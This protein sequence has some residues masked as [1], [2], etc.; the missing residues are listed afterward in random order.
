MTESTLGKLIQS[1]NWN[2]QVTQF[3]T[4]KNANNTKIASPACLKTHHSRPPKFSLHRFPSHF[5]SVKNL[6][7]L[8]PLP[9][10]FAKS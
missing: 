1:K 8:F 3:S 9:T 6:S 7:Y 2:H 10:S 5:S 4:E